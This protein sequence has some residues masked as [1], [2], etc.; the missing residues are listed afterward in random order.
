VP[1]LPWRKEAPL[2]EGTKPDR[3]GDF[4]RRILYLAANPPST[5]DDLQ[6]G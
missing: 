3:L 1:S 2:E 5:Q 4:E 6:S